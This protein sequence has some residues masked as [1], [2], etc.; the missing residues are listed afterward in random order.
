MASFPA[1]QH[2]RLPPA[3]NHYLNSSAGHA[4]ETVSDEE[5]I[6]KAATPE[7]EYVLMSNGL[8]GNRE[9]TD[10]EYVKMSSKVDA[11]EDHNYV[12][13]DEIRDSESAEKTSNNEYVIVPSTDQ[14]PVSHPNY[15][16]ILTAEDNNSSVDHRHL[17]RDSPQDHI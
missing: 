14:K 15:V 6:S 3:E 9:G 5:K 10:N 11:T 7:E 13:S 12:N 2:L 16:N 17:D 1:H 4:Y 8:A